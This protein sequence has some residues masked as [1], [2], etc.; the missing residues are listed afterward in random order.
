M[1]NIG[2]N[3]SMREINRYQFNVQVDDN[4][5]EE[6]Q[7]EQAKAKVAAFLEKN[8]PY[9]FQREPID[10]VLCVDVETIEAEGVVS[11]EVNEK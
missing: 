10:G 3:A 5:S 1:A 9:A 8:T 7:N 11:I 2:L 4:L 6:Q